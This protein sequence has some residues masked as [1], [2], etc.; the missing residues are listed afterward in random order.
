MKKFIVSLFMFSILV[1]TLNIATGITASYKYSREYGS[2][3]NLA[4]KSST[5]KSKAKYIDIF[6][7][8]LENSNFNGQYDALVFK[9]PDNGFNENL[10]ALKTLQKR[11]YEISDMDISSFEYQTAMQQ[12]TAQEQGDADVM[13]SVFK[14]V[15]YKNHYIWL[16]NWIGFIQILLFFGLVIALGLALLSDLDFF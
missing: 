9:T 8:K 14:G 1:T 16:W 15:W 7:D 3:W 12:I 13:L 10:V 6:V 2:Y 11:L 5:I 4:D